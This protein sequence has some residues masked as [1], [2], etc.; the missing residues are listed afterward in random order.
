LFNHL[1]YL[2]LLMNLLG[3]FL[4]MIEHNLHP[5]STKNPGMNQSHPGF[6]NFGDI[7]LSSVF[8]VFTQITGFFFEFF[9]DTEQLVVLGNPVR[10]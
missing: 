4:D 9:L 3:F 7:S 1:I 2:E 6:F 5:E 8:E 10:T